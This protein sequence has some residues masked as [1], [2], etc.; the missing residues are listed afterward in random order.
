MVV[1][2]P[3]VVDNNAGVLPRRIGTKTLDRPEP[4]AETPVPEP[5]ETASSSAAAT[6][7]LVEEVAKADSG[8]VVDIESRTGHWQVAK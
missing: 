7:T 4:T 2:N 1:A 3:S 8:P 6:T 5:K